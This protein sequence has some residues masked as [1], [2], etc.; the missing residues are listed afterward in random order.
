MEIFIVFVALSIIAGVIASKK[1]RSGFGFFLLSL[2]LTPLVG[3]LASLVAS[4]KMAIAGKKCPFCAEI[5]K[6]EA[7]VCKHCGRD[8]PATG[9][10]EV[11]DRYGPSGERL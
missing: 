11:G 7:K 3:I 1:G 4:P 10:E 2:L 9:L 8:L 6:S 5:V